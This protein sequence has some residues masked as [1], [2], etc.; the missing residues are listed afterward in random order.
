MGGPFKNIYTSGCAFKT[1]GDVYALHSFAGSFHPVLKIEPPFVCNVPVWLLRES[2]GQQGSHY[3]SS[4]TPILL[5][6]SS[7]LTDTY[8]ETEKPLQLNTKQLLTDTER[9]PVEGGKHM[10]DFNK[11]KECTISF[12]V[13][14]FTIFK[15]K[16]CKFWTWCPQTELR[17]IIIMM[18]I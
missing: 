10:E 2:T 6:T 16:K 8:T 1:G 12:I 5:H 11:P 17:K 9:E 18:I 14:N 15:D 7:C 3:R 13:E 4:K